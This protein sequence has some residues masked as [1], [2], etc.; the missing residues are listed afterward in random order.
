MEYSGI[1]TEN[2]LKKF[3]KWMF[4]QTIFLWLEN[5]YKLIKKNEYILKIENIFKLVILVN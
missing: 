1:Y 2:F 4:R 3:I 5:F